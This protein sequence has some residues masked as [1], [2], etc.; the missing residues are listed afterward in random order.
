M[1]KFAYSF[2]AAPLEKHAAA[3]LVMEQIHHTFARYMQIIKRKVIE[4]I[5]DFGEK[6]ESDA[7]NFKDCI[8]PF[9]CGCIL[10][11]LLFM[12]VHI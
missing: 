8:F 7:L 12:V 6:V 11:Q 10:F 5:I 3:Y 2:S 1:S 9:L 4:Y